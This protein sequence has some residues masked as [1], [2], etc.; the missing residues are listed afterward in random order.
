MTK[1]FIRISLD[2]NFWDYLF[3]A[4]INNTRQQKTFCYLKNKF[5]VALSSLLTL[6]L[7]LQSG[8]RYDVKFQSVTYIV[9]QDL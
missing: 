5:I 2:K 1:Q 4:I 6:I 8:F 3:F 7:N 9:E